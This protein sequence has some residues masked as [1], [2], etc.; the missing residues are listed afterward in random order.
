MAP[1]ESRRNDFRGRG[2]R[3]IVHRCFDA[4]LAQTQGK[5]IRRIRRIAVNGGIS[6]DNTLL[7]RLVTAPFVIFLNEITEIFPPDEAMQRTNH[8]D[9][10]PRRLF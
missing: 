3:N 5:D 2:H 7:L 8:L 10:E 9:I 6:D 1:F 4:K